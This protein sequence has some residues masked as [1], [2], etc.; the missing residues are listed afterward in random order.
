MHSPKSQIERSRGKPVEVAFDFFRKVSSQPCISEV[1]STGSAV[2]STGLIRSF[3]DQS[4]N[5]V[6]LCAY[7]YVCKTVTRGLV[8]RL[9]E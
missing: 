7:L 5:I 3:S 6:L 8:G 9:A 1:E 2:L 4:N